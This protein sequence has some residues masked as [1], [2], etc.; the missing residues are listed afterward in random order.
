MY[1]QLVDDHV[2]MPLGLEAGAVTALPPRERRLVPRNL[3]GRPRPLWTLTGPILPA[4]GL[5]STCRTLSQ[6][7]TGLLVDRRLGPPAPTW[8]RGSSITWHNGA[9]RGSSVMAA[10]H[11]DGR[12]I[13]LHRLGA[14]DATDDLAR[15]TLLAAPAPRGGA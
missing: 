12:W 5:W 3:F 10:A 1:Q 9:T 15:K 13:V 2:L 4:G 8:Q 14:G 7:V 11:D 6:V